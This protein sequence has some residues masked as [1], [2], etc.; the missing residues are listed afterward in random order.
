MEFILYPFRWLASTHGYEL[1]GAAVGW[2]RE[3][4]LANLVSNIF[5]FLF[6]TSL[7]VVINGFRR[8]RSRPSRYFRHPRVAFWFAMALFVTGLTFLV[9]GTI[10]FYPAYRLLVASNI[11]AAVVWWVTA[12]VSVPISLKQELDQVH[13]ERHNFANKVHTA[14]MRMTANI[15][16]LERLQRTLQDQ[17]RVLEDVVHSIEHLPLPHDPLLLQ[18][19]A[20]QPHQA[21]PPS[22]ETHE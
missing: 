20:T 15:L 11:L 4:I 1:P 6:L 7:A 12:L 18:H 16:R 10:I 2:S 14:D 17:N 5:M 8:Q 19:E 13:E 22:E 9:R 3:M 21:P